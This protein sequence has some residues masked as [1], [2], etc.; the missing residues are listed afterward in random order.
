M[1]F[2]RCA[3]VASFT[4]GTFLVLLALRN[5]RKG[6]A[7]RSWLRVPGSIVRSFVLVHTDNEGTGYVPTVEYE[8]NVE[9][10]KYSGTRLRYGQTGSSNRA[11]AERLIRPYQ[12]GAS[13][14]VFANADRPSEAVLV[15]G[16]SWGNVAIALA[17]VAFLS[18][19]FMLALQ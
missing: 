13:V 6:L 14:E 2:V 5:A 8:Y 17:G 4:A 11:Q 1:W 19:G 16:T 7:A 9:G 12:E 3:E 10:N 18:A 15:P